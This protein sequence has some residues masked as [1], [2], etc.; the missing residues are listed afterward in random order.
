MRVQEHL[1]FHSFDGQSLFY[2]HWPAAS[3]ASPRRALVLLHR[4]HE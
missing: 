4:G 3:S 2:R 1:Q